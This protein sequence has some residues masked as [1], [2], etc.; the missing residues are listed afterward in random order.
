M[1]RL[2]A[3]V[4]IVFVFLS[5]IPHYLCRQTS[6]LNSNIIVVCE[7]RTVYM[8]LILSYFADKVYN[9]KVLDIKR[10]S[11][12]D[13]EDYNFYYSLG[14]MDFYRRRDLLRDYKALVVT[15]HPLDLFTMRYRKRVSYLED[16]AD[17]LNGL[18]IRQ[19]VE[20][21]NTTVSTLY[22][23]T[24]GADSHVLLEL[25][26]LENNNTDIMFM[27]SIDI[28]LSKRLSGKKITDFLG[29]DKTDWISVSSSV[30]GKVQRGTKHR[31]Y[32]FP[33]VMSCIHYK[34]FEAIYGLNSLC[35]FG[36][37]DSI[38]LYLADKKAKCVGATEDVEYVANNCSCY[39]STGYSFG[40]VGCA[41][42]PP[43]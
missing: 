43:V 37:G 5:L 34:H 18:S 6:T 33:N 11:A 15:Q 4:T 1:V 28:K 42:K 26:S 2:E 17:F 29:I 19:Y 31:P 22:D 30:I 41:Y 14:Y 27:R 32:N 38:D 16:K 25:I 9:K 21:L 10:W 36:Y 35:K 24:C 7:T 3:L 8:Y 40:F 20:N 23:M 13:S 12:V 39:D